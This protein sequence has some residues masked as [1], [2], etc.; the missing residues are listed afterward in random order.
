MS[1]VEPV[2]WRYKRNNQN[3]FAV[4][5][6]EPSRDWDVVEPLYTK[7][8]LQP[9]VKMTKRQYARLMWD[10]ENTNLS[11]CL[12]YFLEHDGVSKFGKVSDNL[13]GLLKQEDIA[14]AWLNPEETIEIV[15]NM[16]WFVRSKNKAK[17][18]KYLWLTDAYYLD[19]PQFMFTNDNQS[20]AMKF[21][22]KEEAEEWKN[23]L[24]E[25]VLLPVEE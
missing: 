22:S 1:E 6:T 4:S 24:T 2:A 7:E 10:K 16:K 19:I 11:T 25:A 14:R 3:V 21:G 12:E 13:M 15:P 23:P 5:Q 20:S 18:G 8:Q 9:R 17:N